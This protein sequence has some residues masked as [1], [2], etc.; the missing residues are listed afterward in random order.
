MG[1]FNDNGRDR[2]PG[3]RRGSNDRR[4][5]ARPNLESLEN[6]RLLTGSSTLPSWKPTS[7]D[8]ADV[9]N[10]PLA[11]TG[12]DLIKVYQD[13]QQ[14]T[15][16]GGAGAFASSSM[17][18]M[19]KSIK[20]LGDYVAIS[21]YA[22][23]D[24]NAYVKQVQDIGM[25]VGGY[26]VTSRLVEGLLPISK[27]PTL[28]GLAQTD[29]VR[30]QA[31]AITYSQGSANNQSQQAQLADIGATQFNVDGS[32]VT[33]GVLSASVNRFQNGLA[34]S[35]RTGDIPKKADGT[36]NVN[37]LF[38]SD[39]PNGAPTNDDEGRAML[40]HVYDIAPGAGLAYYNAFSSTGGET[41]MAAGIRNLATQAGA[42]VIIDD[43]RF[44]FEGFYQDGPAAVA[45][46]D[47]T[48]NNGVSYFSS[49]GNSADKGYESPFRGVTSTVTGIGA[50]RFMN[51][52]PSG[53]Q[54]LLLPIV[55]NTPG[56]T[57]MQFDQ[58]F[59]VPNGV[60]SDV[61][62]YILD[63]NG[64][65]VA[66]GVSNNIATNQPYESLNIPNAGNF[67]M[68]IVVKAGSPDPGRVAVY[69]FFSDVDFS[70]KF[71]NAGGIN[72]PT[73][74]GHPTA[75]A[76]IGVGAV[77]WFSTPAFP[78]SQVS[79][80]PS[81]SFTSYGPSVKVYNADGSL[82]PAVEFQQTPVLS[83]ADGG[84]VSFTFGN[85][86]GTGVAPGIPANNYTQYNF[87]GTSDAAPDVGAVAAL[88]KQLSPNSSPSA[89][90]TALINSTIPLNG[91]PKG[92]WDVRG[93]FGLVQAPTALAAVDNLRV[94]SASPADK[95][96]VTTAPQYLV[97]NFSRDVDYRTINASDLV[98]TAYSVAGLNISVGQPLMDLNN[99]TQVFFPISFNLAP[100]AKAFGAYAYT[101]KA[102]SITA[103][104]GKPLVG[105]DGSFGVFDAIAPRVI[106][107]VI[108]GRV[109]T[110]TFSEPMNPASITRNN[111]YLIRTGASGVFGSPTNVVVNQDPRI[112]I[113]YDVATNSA[114]LDF[115]NVDQ[116]LLPTDHY[117]LVLLD[118]ATD[119]V[120]N[121]LDG[122]YSGIFPSGDGN[123]GGNFTQDL[124]V[125]ILGAPQ[126]LSL[127]LAPASDTGI[128]GDQNTM[129]S[130]PTFVG[131]VQAK[132][133]GSSA[134]LTVVAQ[135]NG[136]RGG[137]FD[138]T[139]GLS[140]RGFSGTVD[141]STTTD[142]TGRF[143]F[144][145]PFTLPSGFQTVRVIVVGASEQA[146][147]PGLSTQ[148]DST[149]RV[150][151]NSPILIADPNSIQQNS[152]I[153]GLTSVVIDAVDP[154]MPTNLGN[155]LS[156]PTQ[157]SVPALN[158]ATA[159]NISNYSLLN[160]GSDN[161]LGGT[162][163]AAD[164]DY[165]SYITSA[166][167][168]AT[169]QR[170]QTTDPFLGT[171][172]LT[173][174][175]GLPA[176]KY[177]L[178]AHRPGPGFQGIT[179]AA[180]NAIYSALPTMV[181]PVD[182]VLAF[183]LQP[184]PAYITSVQALTPNPLGAVRDPANQ[185]IRYDT[186]APRS[187]FELAVPGTT[188]RALDAPTT[189][190]ID[191]S[192]PLNTSRDYNGLVQL[193]R[194][195]NGVL[196]QPDGDF[197]T[198][199]TFQSGIGYTIV[200]NTTV[201]LVNSI[202]GATFGQPGYKN[203]LVVSLAPGT[204]LPADHYRL[205]V[206][207][208]ITPA[209]KDERIL[210]QFGN[211][212]DG[213]F[214]GNP[215]PNGDGK[216]ENLLS[217]GQIR[218]NDM[219]G[220]GVPGGA[221]E[222]GYTVVP[223][224]NVIFVQPDYVDD[225]SLAPDDPDGSLAH[226][227]VALAP[228]ATPNTLNGG[229]L[230]SGANFRTGFD[231]NYDRNGNGHFDR[232]AFVA[233]AALSARGPVVIVA[234]PAATDKS[235]TFVLQAPSG[236]DP[237]LNDGSATVPFDT[238]LVFDA[239]SVLKLRN[240]SL[241]VQNQGS[242]IQVKGGANPS[243][244]VYFTSYSDD[245]IGGDTNNDGPSSGPL[246]GDWGGI[247]LRNFDDT[248]NGG[249]PVPVAPG[250]QDPL[251]AKL[252]ISGADEA[253]SYLDHA[254]IRYAGGAVPQ[255]IGF[256]YDAVTNFNTRATLTNLTISQTGGGNS[257]QAAISG[258]VD[259]FRQDDL[260]RGI[261]V[262][263]DNVFNNS[264]NGIYVRAELN[265]VAEP[266]DAVV[267]PDNP[268]SEGGTQNYSFFAPL[269]YV[270]VSRLVIGQELLQ[271]QNGLTRPTTNRFYFQPGTVVKFQRGAAIDQ[272]TV[273]SSLNIG[274][275]TYLREFDANNNLSPND[276]GYRAPDFGD[277]QVLFTSFF[278]DKA[279]TGF[280]DPNTGV[281]TPI[282]AAID[283]DNGGP[284]N[285]PVAGNVPPLARWGGIS[286]TSGAI[287]VI[288]EATFQFGGGSVNSAGGTI[289][290]RD[291]L[292]FQGS[293]ATA[294]RRNPLGTTAYVS[295]SNFFDNLQAP[296]SD[297]PN[298][299]LATDPLRPLRS[300]NPF[301]RGN[302]ML[303]NQLN[304]LEILP[305]T[306]DFAGYTANVFTDTVWDDTDLTYILRNTLR[307]AG[308]EF[309]NSNGGVF[310]AGLPPA[311][312]PSSPF[313]PELKPSVTLT[314]QSSL[315]DSLLANG[316]R[317]ARPGES[318]LVKLLNTT[319]P[320]GDGANGFPIGNTGSDFQGGAGIIA[321]IDDGV[322]PPGDPLVDAGYLSQLRILGIG[323]NQTTGQQRVP[324]IITS[325][326]D[327]TAGRTVRGVD[328]FQ[329][330][331]G[332]TTAPAPGDGGVFAFGALGLSDYNLLDPRDGNLIDNADIRYITRIEQ[333]GGGWVY[334]S[335]DGAYQD[336]IGITPSTQYNTAKAM[337]V[338]N[339]N[340]ANFSQTGFLAHPSN[341]TQ[342]S[343]I[344]GIAGGPALVA[345][346]TVTYGQPTLTF[347]VN[348]TFANMPTAVRIN[349][350][351]VGIDGVP[352]ESPAEAIFLNN[353]FYNNGEAIRA[354]GAA[355]T[356]IN[357][358][359][360]V[361]LI[362]MDNIF[363]NSTIA[364]INGVN[365]VY[366]SQGQYNLFSSNAADVLGGIANNQPVFGNP[367]FRNPAAGDFSLMPNSDAIDS[368]RSE[369]GPLLLGN[370]LQPIVTQV[371]NAST[372]TRRATGRTNPFGGL[373]TRISPSDIISLP[374]FNLRDYKDQW[375]PALTGSPGAIP[376][377]STNAGG[378]YS[379]IPI[380]G[381]R[382][383]AGQLRVDD[384]N[385]ANV[386]FGNRPFFD[387]GASEYLLLN[388]PHIT[389]VTAIINN[390]FVTPTNPAS[391]TN[392]ATAQVLFYQAG[393]IVGA[394]QTPHKIL[395]QL[396]QRLDPTTIN[397]KTIILQ[398]ANGDGIFDNGND[399]FLDLS[400]KLVYDAAGQFIAINLAD[401]G[402]SL[403]NDVYRLEVFGSGGS[404]L[405]NPQGLALD[406]ENTVGDQP[407]APTLPLPSGDGFPGGNFFLTFTIDTHAPAIV[408][409][410]LA[411]APQSDSGARDNITS[412]S[413]PS[414]I[415]TVTDTAPP[416]NPVLGQTVFIDVSTK[417]DGNFDRIGVAT[418][419][420]D[421]NG[422]FT[423][424]FD[425]KQK[426]LPETSYSV[427]PDGI[428][429]TA[430]DSGYSVARVRIVDQ[431]GNVSNLNDPNAFVPFVV[432]TQG[433]RVLSSSP[434]PGAQAA[435]SVG[436]V[437]VAIVFNEN[438]APNTLTVNSVKV[439]R[440]GGDG[441]LGNANDVPVAI[442]PASLVIQN[443]GS[444][445][446]SE[447]VRF[448]IIGAT[449]NDIYRVTLIG[450][451]ATAVT[452]VAGNALDGE[453]N[454][455]PTGDGTP[456]GNFNLDF[457]VFNPAAAKIRFVGKTVTSPTATLGSR[458]KPYA[459]I[460]LAMADAQPGDTVAVLP[461]VYTET[462]TLRSLVHL[463]SADNTS[464]DASLVHGNA[465]QTIIRAPAPANGTAA[466]TTIQGD[467]LTSISA[468]TTEVSGF[469]IASPLVGD[470]ARGPI[471]TG[472]FAVL[473]NSSDVLFD[474]NYIIDS[475][476]GI[477][478]NYAGK[479][480]AVPRFESNVFAG[481]VY[482]LLSNDVGTVNF[483]DGRNIQVINNDFA[484]NTI[485]YY[486]QSNTTAG[487]TLSTVSNNIFWENADHSTARN[488]IA[489]F[490]T[491]SNRTALQ[492]NLFSGNGPSDTN[493]A[494]DTLN[495]G[496]GFNP[497]TLSANPDVGGN[498]AGSPVFVSPIDPRPDGSG[499]GNFFLGANF[500]LQTSSA[501]IDLALNSL[502]PTVDF[503]FRN[504]V[505]IAGK[506]RPGAGPADIG[507][508]EY[509]GTLSPG[510]GGTI[511][512]SAADA[513]TDGGAAALAAATPPAAVVP[514]AST[515]SSG[516]SSVTTRSITTGT[517]SSSP[518]TGTT[519]PVA[520]LT[521]G[522]KAA[523][524]KAAV[525]QAAAEKAAAHKAATRAA[526]KPSG[527]LSLV[528]R[529][530][531][532][533]H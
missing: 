96:G 495:I 39:L 209:G 493:P 64:T 199:P 131:Q 454:T 210:D 470:S 4:R 18:S 167:F 55:V 165:S 241:F 476:V 179:D 99:L 267:H 354:Q 387:I 44:A 391:P 341:T 428:L 439:V 145:A 70:H 50:G 397:N 358:L 438:I 280:R 337:T 192:N 321:G 492:Y 134:G 171:I 73:T 264:I 249:R 162:G 116:A 117:G 183:D 509:R 236:T 106:N 124:G 347:F 129:D 514:Q 29:G 19:A 494:D 467:N 533:G 466:T 491:Q 426:P 71:G 303:R 363:A 93:G 216:F 228:E 294:R 396:D 377:P 529:F 58:P 251:R 41:V 483:K 297:D 262:R 230:N 329:A 40:E 357:P 530:F 62:I 410:S 507:A 265:G 260:A 517:T 234:E 170:V 90:R 223:N 142:A 30:A 135:F 350:D 293:A 421:R 166:T 247:V 144:K 468:F 203:R 510:T 5:Q 471:N 370:S 196:A 138:L 300:G 479:A 512:T 201:T 253:L 214:L 521:K 147:L 32:G 281:I 361:H 380:Q 88:M 306:G 402:L 424:V 126:I 155:P 85:P 500:D 153:S 48:Q 345:R 304:G 417:G 412:V 35:V 33:V 411:L 42:K 309:V 100:G 523:A 36:A 105:F 286:V 398:V 137:T 27:L 295:N 448:N 28:A 450:T 273:G 368:S 197:G 279:T 420:T 446:G 453:G 218:P 372:G 184:T 112:T 342:L 394:N 481:N 383:Q 478:V 419:V 248:S 38:D 452:D 78:N 497:A 52:D 431:A 465:L 501:A 464:T 392:P 338:S 128:A 290:Q 24:L 378:T 157:F 168:A 291:M 440:A 271:D 314:I 405:R 187:F 11:N 15:Q 159:N 143:T 451:G 326:R 217:T 343:V 369:I 272:I 502:A 193:I 505:D 80:T 404:V 61:D 443:L 469:T 461:G 441:V 95:A 416:A 20:F 208:Q 13:Y 266:T 130:A 65:V 406:G 388:P 122:E 515:P 115:T 113:K 435:S 188:P 336:R 474:K 86:P 407:N 456:G 323:G 525:K 224:G 432:D 325:L 285:L 37:V 221:F 148:L 205:Y 9:K 527:S 475:G 240:A 257:A 49:A 261:L 274:D 75:D 401:S 47:V 163:T 200:P 395:L 26:D 408:A 526:S 430:D 67:S 287:A 400:G 346:A 34:D 232:S 107:T 367:Q 154:V 437:P 219:T 81:E 283:S 477:G 97:F 2:G 498:I 371:L 14:Y 415:G 114:I 215:T 352:Q 104:D 528:N 92:T 16:A 206:P 310:G 384:P 519:T 7:L 489:I 330:S 506:G 57:V 522:Q 220:D 229:D 56:L 140:G 278:D 118:S 531:K 320:I 305:E 386:G 307:L 174:S 313:L 393:G 462:V 60:T 409:T 136:V 301:F 21:T 244:Q 23:G 245:A 455:F 259:S 204:T 150:D 87:F 319:A 235:K 353:T 516:G 436:V 365:Q 496:G 181:A 298:G 334:V 442:D 255:T 381:E 139:Q 63:A 328:M 339:S 127:S 226:P 344:G 356:G 178:I 331:S 449:A 89:I 176:G 243:D 250:P 43:V 284:V 186:S 119:I 198:D 385:R 83:G 202:L 225:P 390:P 445:S 10:G 156:I 254:N 399:K 177:N 318:A 444:T 212:L 231:P 6:R 289:G 366:G 333:Q 239:G 161:A 302:V 72:Y 258:D 511:R 84:N 327:D 98:F 194:S 349:S 315:P 311:P 141:V 82:K 518:T 348:N 94:V 256:R 121:K 418:G 108:S 238:T 360:H 433:P 480:A 524:H 472:S 379:Y 182:F 25:V 103:T 296:I 79:P 520:V 68:A 268:T 8:I 340:L 123:E 120:G 169:G 389:L 222:T 473:L 1:S 429:G 499:P 403:A 53:G 508:F 51:F 180:G 282:V 373:G 316:Q 190:W 91:T 158:P 172:T 189:F 237:V 252:G 459:T 423:A 275:R 513:P 359:A 152:R 322:D 413:T 207:N 427:G 263:R 17:N 191:F 457:I 175:P 270:L 335:T 133:P 269:P 485:G 74:F 414:F 211:Q 486:Q 195:A 374:G 425:T 382:D 460:T 111:F 160:L 146:P 488:G 110:A 324:V 463:V 375:I 482:G 308:A 434:L 149:F 46:T 22:A 362:A 351:Q 12:A 484:F 54:T 487:I 213:E 504:R 277:A 77:P 503:L 185:S 102:G 151:I 276:V 332:N 173:F 45:I 3:R 31:P 227:Y 242:S 109:I 312:D 317:I 125:R 355:A 66:S 376:G 76:A 458:A 233:A 364:A 59:G 292:A 164:T 246:G 490:A 422:N 69:S 447:I 101:L 288:D 299:L 532:K 132:F